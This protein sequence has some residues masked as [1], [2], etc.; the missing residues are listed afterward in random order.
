M[1][2]SSILRRA[3]LASI[4]AFL[5]LSIAG[6]RAVGVPPIAD[7]ERPPNVVIIFTDDLGYADVGPFGAE[8]Y[9]TPNLDRMAREGVRFTDFYVSQA[10]CSASR[11]ALLTG[12]YS[13]R[14]GILG[15]LGPG[16]KIGINA[17]EV[18]IPELL[19]PRGYATAIFG[20]WHLGDRPEF[21]P[22]RHG[23]DEY[24]GLPYSNDM[25]PNHPT[26]KSFPDLPLIEG[27]ETTELNPDQ[28]NLTTWYAEHA[29][30]FIERNRDTAILPLPRAQHAARTVVRLRQV[31]REDRR[32]GSSATSSRRSTGRLARS[33]TLSKRTGND[34]RTLVIFTSDNGP[35]LSYGDHAGSAGVFREGKGT[36]FEGGVREPFIARWP[37]KIPEGTV[38][39]EPAMTI[40]LL[41]T[42]AGL[43][44]ATVPQERIIDGLD[45][46]PL[47]SG[48][49][50]AE[51]PHVALYF[52]YGRELQG[53]RGGK[54]KLHLPH[55]YRSLKGEPGSGGLP[56]PYEQKKISLAL[57]DLD[58]DPGET[59]DVAEAYPGVVEKLKALA[60]VARHDLG[61]S[62]SNQP[63]ENVRGTQ[64]L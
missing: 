39:R 19:K 8:G 10:V 58:A 17:D 33:S 42:I 64:E 56:G 22:T 21:L 38:C 43:A 18:L 5:A 1:S 35:W 44:G 46:W 26:N 63:G 54:W 20:K 12:C 51:S 14:V 23:F 28:H 13:N 50:G 3:V 29:V 15:A 61:D 4:V 57:F 30:R 31:R 16:S 7:D 59:T 34:E 62:A 27:T 60:E 6:Q 55:S 37:G 2:R 11:A 40:D 36:S 24:F 49:E 9:K 52:Y 48:V 25:W 45:I 47:L 53:V 32:A 41:P